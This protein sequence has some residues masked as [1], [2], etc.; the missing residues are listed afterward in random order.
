M[1]KAFQLHETNVIA[2]LKYLEVVFMINIGAFWFDEIY[3]FYTFVGIFLI[4][5][6]LIYNLFIKKK[7]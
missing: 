6:G 1:T 2:P 3:N 4:L 7:G 5:F